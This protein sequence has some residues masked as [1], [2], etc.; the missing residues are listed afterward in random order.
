MEQLFDC[1]FCIVKMVGGQ[2]DGKGYDKSNIY[3]SWKM[4]VSKVEI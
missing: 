2:I 3:R 4:L 1:V